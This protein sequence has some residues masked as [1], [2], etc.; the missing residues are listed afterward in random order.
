MIKII[1]KVTYSDAQNEQPTEAELLKMTSR[2]VMPSHLSSDSQA[3]QA[4]FAKF[5]TLLENDTQ[6]VPENTLVSS[7]LR[8]TAQTETLSSWNHVLALALSLLVFASFAVWHLPH[9]RN[10]QAIATLHRENA[11]NSLTWHDDW[12]SQADNYNSLLLYSHVSQLNLTDT[13]AQWLQ[14][15]LQ[16]E[17]S[18]IEA[19]SM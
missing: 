1:M 19:E 5:A 16:E 6:N 9:Q 10:M 8:K 3:L 4:A 11:G 12:D 13:A 18:Q 7:I 17:Q 2:Q 15:S 14:S